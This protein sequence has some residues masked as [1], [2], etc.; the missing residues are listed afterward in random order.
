ML[1][2]CILNAMLIVCNRVNFFR[3]AFAYLDSQSF[4]QLYFPFIATSA[5]LLQQNDPAAAAFV[6]TGSV[7]YTNDGHPTAVGNLMY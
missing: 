4:V 5:A 6:G 7:L 2:R 3:Q 1:T